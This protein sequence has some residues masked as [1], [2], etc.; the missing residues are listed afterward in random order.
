MLR[1]HYQIVSGRISL[2]MVFNVVIYRKCILL[3]YLVQFPDFFFPFFFF[4]LLKDPNAVVRG[5]GELR[6]L[7]M[8]YGAL[9]FQV[10]GMNLTLVS[11]NQESLSAGGCLVAYDSQ[12]GGFTLCNDPWLHTH[13]HSL[14]LKHVQIAG[15]I[16]NIS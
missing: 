11:N 2:W 6:M 15:E 12:A 13:T 10:I 9:F 5:T 3:K 7:V 16:L 8:R 1:M 14:Q 4:L